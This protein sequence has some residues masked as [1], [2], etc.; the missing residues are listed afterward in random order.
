MTCR[1][2][3]CFLAPPSATKVVTRTLWMSFADL[4]SELAL[5]QLRQLWTVDHCHEGVHPPP[6]HTAQVHFG[7]IFFS[8]FV[9]YVFMAMGFFGRTVE[10]GTS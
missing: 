3:I 7:I 8:V 2:P 4:A 10:G 9:T 5:C 6:M 1:L